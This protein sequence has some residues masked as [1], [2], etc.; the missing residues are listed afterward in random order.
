MAVVTAIERL[1]DA[2]NYQ[3]ERHEQY[4][5]SRFGEVVDKE[6]SYD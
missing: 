2:P 1:P 3:Y 5:W 6:A 4:E